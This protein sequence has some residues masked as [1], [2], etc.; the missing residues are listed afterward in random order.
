MTK[1]E[2][3]AI[4]HGKDLRIYMTSLSDATKRINKK[5]N[6]ILEGNHGSL[7]K[8]HMNNTVDSIKTRVINN[9]FSVRDFVLLASVFLFIKVIFMQLKRRSPK[10]ISRMSECTEMFEEEAS[11]LH[12]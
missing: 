8:G 12:G 10:L 4:R 6:D 11:F 1:D 3:R 7:A 5:C 9:N 2:K